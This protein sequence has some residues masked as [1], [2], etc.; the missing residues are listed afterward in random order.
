MWQQTHAELQSQ[1]HS[2]QM[3]TDAIVDKAA[4]S[5]Q[6]E[7]V[8]QAVTWYLVCATMLQA[9]TA[10]QTQLTDLQQTHTQLQ[11][12]SDTKQVE[13]DTFADKASQCEKREEVL[14]S[15]L[16]SQRQE[17]ETLRQTLEQAQSARNQAV[18]VCAYVVEPVISFWRCRTSQTLEQAQSARNQALQVHISVS[19][20][21][22]G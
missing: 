7:E 5:Q 12:Q 9:K 11:L 4:Q 21:S 15:Q 6:Q 22:W 16:F 19:F 1:N 13:F 17:C 18:Q 3:E 10:L 8:L 14:K 2:K 20:R